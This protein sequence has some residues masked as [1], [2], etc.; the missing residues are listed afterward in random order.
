M[1]AASL[2]ERFRYFWNKLELPPDSLGLG[3]LGGLCSSHQC[4]IDQKDTAADA[5]LLYDMHIAHVVH[6]SRQMSRDIPTSVK[7]D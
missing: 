4:D 1:L 6:I 2:V 7:L 5:D 3:H